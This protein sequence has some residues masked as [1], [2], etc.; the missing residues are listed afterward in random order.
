MRIGIDA[1]MLGSGFGLARY[2]QQLVLHLQKID[3]ENQY[4]LFLKSDNWDE[5]GESDNFKKVLADIHWYGCFSH[6]Q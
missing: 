3:K 6:F 1:R 4:V 2:V 5:V